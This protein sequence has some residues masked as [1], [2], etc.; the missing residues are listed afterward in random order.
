LARS[1]GDAVK[2]LSRLALALVPLAPS[3]AT[4]AERIQ[5]TLDTSEAEA[6]LAIARKRISNQPVVDSD[7]RR[8]LATEPYQRLKKRE[9]GM[10]RDFSDEDLK[11]FVL[12]DDLARKA[13]DLAR[14]LE[15]WKQAD[16]RAAAARVLA[17]LPA[18]CM[19]D[20]RKLL[21]T[22]NRAAARH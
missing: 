12:A 9:A 21:P 8:L 5:L 3:V 10:H 1:P 7:W 15:Q 11:K 2:R 19:S 18:E 20:F 14:T 22:Y 17:Y 6:V 16:L 13:A 4:A